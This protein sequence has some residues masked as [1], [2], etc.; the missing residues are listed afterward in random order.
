MALKIA[1]FTGHDARTEKCYGIL[2]SAVSVSLTGTSAS[3][4]TPPEGAYIARIRAGETC[5]VSNNGA[6]ASDTNGIYMEAGDAIDIQV[7]G[8]FYAKTTT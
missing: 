1:Y 8:P 6:A 5:V 7:D 4:G 2:R 3:C